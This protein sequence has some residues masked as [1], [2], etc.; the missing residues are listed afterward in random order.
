MIRNRHVLDSG[1]TDNLRG[2]MLW[3]DLRETSPMLSIII[4]M[5]GRVAAR[6]G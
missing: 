6:C 4:S 3:F 5:P 1:E 2:H